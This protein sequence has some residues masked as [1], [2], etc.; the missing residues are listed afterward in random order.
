MFVESL[1]FFLIFDMMGKFVKECFGVYW[2]YDCGIIIIFIIIIEILLII[3][4]L[5]LFYLKLY[6]CLLLFNKRVV[7]F[8]FGIIWRYKY[9]G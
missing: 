5:Y 8:I 1:F 3:K 7:V 4:Y 9:V 6:K 2:F